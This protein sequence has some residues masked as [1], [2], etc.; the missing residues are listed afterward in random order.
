M[1]R[2]LLISVLV[3]CQLMVNA[4]NIYCVALNPTPKVTSIKPSSVDM[5]PKIIRVI[6]YFPLKD[7]GINNNFTETTDCYGKVN[8]YT[9]YWFAETL[10]ER[11]NLSLK[12]NVAMRQYLRKY[13][14]GSDLG[15]PQVN[16]INIQLELAGVVFFRDNMLYHVGKDS[17]NRDILT[18]SSNMNVATG[19]ISNTN[20]KDAINIFVYPEIDGNGGHGLSDGMSV[21]LIDGVKN[22]YDSYKNDCNNGGNG[23]WYFESLGR[24][25]SHEIGHCLNLHHPKMSSMGEKCSKNDLTCGYDDGLT[26]TPTYPELIQDGWKDP[27]AW[28]NNEKEGIVAS[29][30]VMDYNASQASWTPQQIAMVHKTIIDRAKSGRY[31]YPTSFCTNS[32][33]TPSAIDNINSV[34]VAKTVT[35]KNTKVKSGKALYVNC[36]EFTVTGPFEVEK[37]AVLDVK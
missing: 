2:L 17:K 24:L 34:I 14:K 19:K 10:I 26:D 15:I 1:K 28:N 33:T 23:L 3:L 5:S 27:Y 22:T 7:S 12:K 35:S 25:M 30:N 20:L 31:L 16:D 37:G 6:V 11:T 32:A 9:G 21:C 18:V 13:T 8:S 29:N 36:D 4:Q